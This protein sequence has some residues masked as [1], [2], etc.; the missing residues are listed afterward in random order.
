[1]LRSSL[2]GDAREKDAI[3][4]YLSFLVCRQKTD[5]AGRH[6]KNKAQL[7]RIAER[8]SGGLILPLEQAQSIMNHLM[9]SE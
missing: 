7:R 6:P 4:I 8:H 3:E 2:I 1:L 5:P 9:G